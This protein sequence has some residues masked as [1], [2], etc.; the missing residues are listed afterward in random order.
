MESAE[1]A[2]AGAPK[3]V[4]DQGTPPRV[5][6]VWEPRLIE[7]PAAPQAPQPRAL[8]QFYSLLDSLGLLD[9]LERVEPEPS[10]GT[11]EGLRAFHTDAYL[12]SVA[13][14]SEGGASRW[15]AEAAGFDTLEAP[16]FPGMDELARRYVA[17]ARTAVRLASGGTYPRVIALSG[18]QGHARA[19]RAVAGAIYNDVLVPLIDARV[20][21]ERV[22]FVNLDPEYPSVVADYFAQDPGLLFVSLH[23]SGRYL[24]PGGGSP[25]E[26]GRGEG[27]GY[28]VNLPLAPGAGDDEFLLALETTVLPLLTRY[29][30]QLMVVL[31][32][33][34]AHRDAPLAH[35]A[36]GSRGID[37]LIERLVEGQQRVVYLGGS[38]DDAG[39]AAR[40]WTLV[41]ARLAGRHQRLPERLPRRYVEQWGAGTLHDPRP[42]RLP[43]MYAAFA[44]GR[45]HEALARAQTALFTHW[46][47]EP[48]LD[49]AMKVDIAP[50]VELLVAAPVASSIPYPE[51]TGGRSARPRR[52]VGGAEGRG[53]GDGQPSRK[54]RRRRRRGK[55]RGGDE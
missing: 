33:V 21:F 52:S 29:D 12:Q 51:P 47:Q 15:S 17:S 24:F 14:L 39:L 8:E 53:S 22:A 48:T 2:P 4:P 10:L 18:R 3:K 1:A 44:R 41:A 46:G 40:L 5:A 9:A 45:T 43:A 54:R 27:T 30:P 28:T 37:R 23:E 7:T 36:A 26:I 55:K 35:L 50:P 34:G 13:A 42:T 32:G 25:D 19:D 6:L 20:A 49:L 38:A 11:R 31:G 16:P